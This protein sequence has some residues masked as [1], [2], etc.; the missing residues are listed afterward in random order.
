MKNAKNRAVS[1]FIV[2]SFFAHFRNVKARGAAESMQNVSGEKSRRS[3]SAEISAAK[4]AE[5]V[6]GCGASGVISGAVGVVCR[7]CVAPAGCCEG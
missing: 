6:G 4:S 5:T 7:P 1:G 3:C 2:I